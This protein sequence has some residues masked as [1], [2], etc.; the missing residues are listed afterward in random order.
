MK[1]LEIG[2]AS[3]ERARFWR[4][5]LKQP[6][7]VVPNLE[8]PTRQAFEHTTILY[9][10]SWLDH[11]SQLSDSQPHAFCV[12]QPTALTER[13]TGQAQCLSTVCAPPPIGTASRPS[14]RARRSTANGGVPLL[15]EADRRFLFVGSTPQ[16]RKAL[17][18][19][20]QAGLRSQK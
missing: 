18:G 13:Q 5:Y 14:S 11:A 15:A 19:R 10:V 9:M 6:E 20:T 17:S 7:L 3:P 4:V 16:Q 12:C 2:A 1:P 8:G